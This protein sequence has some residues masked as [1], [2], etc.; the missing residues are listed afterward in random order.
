MGNALQPVQPTPVTLR[1]L[2]AQSGSKHLGG[3]INPQQGL[4]ALAVIALSPHDGILLNST[5][6]EM[7]GF[8]RLT[9]SDDAIALD[10]EPLELYSLGP[11]DED[12][13]SGSC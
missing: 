2:L 7:I 9:R 4:Q 6:A 8:E 11:I 5:T 3:G 13:G 12:D 1:Q 10:G